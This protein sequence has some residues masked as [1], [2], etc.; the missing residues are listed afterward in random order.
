MTGR[1]QAVFLDR[2]G[3][4]MED[5]HYI[6]SPDQVRLLPGA[7]AAVRRINE[8][9]IPA[10]VVTN[11]SGIGRGLFGLDEY[12]AVRSHFESL[13]RA[14]GAHIDA[15]YF[16]PHHPSVAEA[17]TCRKPATKMFE[18]AARDL[19]LDLRRTAYIGD[20][21]RDV[22]ASKKLGGRGI[23]VESP[24]TTAEDRRL[25]EQDGIETAPTIVEAVS[26]LLDLPA[27]AGAH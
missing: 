12:E 8:A 15:S 19:G 4:I 17:L 11:Q 5:A 3:T 10:I 18:D 13:L 2:D 14:E 23:M 16:C 26:M 20:R 9:G 1:P 22:V 24:M 25:A 21:W 7:A 6:K 27:G